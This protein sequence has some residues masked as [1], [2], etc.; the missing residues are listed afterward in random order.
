[1]T[2]G[3]FSQKG[4]KMDTLSVAISLPAKPSELHARTGHADFQ[5]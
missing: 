3:E 5:E 1:M 2:K 4:G